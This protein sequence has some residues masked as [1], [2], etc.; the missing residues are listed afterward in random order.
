M[1]AAER[2]N[3]IKKTLAAEQ[4]PISASALAAKFS[5]SRQV[6]VGD[7]A[8]LRT[9][10]E[11][12]SATPRGYIIVR[13]E[14]GIIHQIVCRHADEEIID[15][16]NAIV[17]HGCS[18]VNVIVE[19]PVY[20]QITGDL[21]ISSRYDVGIFYKTLCEAAAPQLSSLTGGIHIHTVSCPD[22]EAFLRVEQVLK[23]KG[24]LVSTI[25]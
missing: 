13:S 19:H 8:L 1:T 22:E 9:A 10:G 24:I 6:I 7:I 20:G 12:I 16:L 23:E 17:D 2:R 21:R 14:M 11:N 4:K 5:V 25:N 3:E 18:V 15:E